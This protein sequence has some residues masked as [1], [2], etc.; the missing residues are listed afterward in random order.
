MYPS[1]ASNLLRCQG[2]SWTPDPPASASWVLQHRHGLPCFPTAVWGVNPGILCDRQALYQL[3]YIPAPR[4]T[5]KRYVNQVYYR[6]KA[7][8]QNQRLFTNFHLKEFRAGT[9]SLTKAQPWE[10]I[11]SR[12]EMTIAALV[13]DHVVKLQTSVLADKHLCNDQQLT[14]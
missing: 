6:K 14:K 11:D 4:Y 9:I 2:R 12:R 7:K 1:L 10:I 8:I 13:T 5:V 3:N